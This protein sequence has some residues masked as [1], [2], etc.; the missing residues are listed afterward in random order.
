MATDT[1]SVLS[2]ADTPPRRH[3]LPH[4][5]GDTETPG[6][7]E[8]ALMR[9]SL[10]GLSERTERCGSCGRTLLLGERVYEYT[11]GAIRC[12]LCRDSA[13]QTPTDSHTVHGPEFGHSIRV[14]DRR[15]P[16]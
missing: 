16:R 9:R 3:R 15:I 10:A 12:E 4:H 6:A 7:L 5:H 11:S 2:T 8:L 1:L 14:I 13:G